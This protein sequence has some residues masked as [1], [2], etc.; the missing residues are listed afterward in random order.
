MFAQ[1]RKEV[2]PCTVCDRVGENFK[3]KDPTLKS[4]PIMVTIYRCGADRCKMPVTSV[5]GRK[6]VVVM[7]GHFP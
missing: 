4:L 7:I 6:Y 5:S 3:G 1:V 2:S